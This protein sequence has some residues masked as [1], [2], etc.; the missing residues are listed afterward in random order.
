MENY[1]NENPEKCRAQCECLKTSKETASVNLSVKENKEKQLL[2][3]DDKM[4]KW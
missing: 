4:E 3:I 2:M 1:R